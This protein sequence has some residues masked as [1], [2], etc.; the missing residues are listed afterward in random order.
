VGWILP[1]V[2]LPADTGDSTPLQENSK[3]SQE[4]DQ[5]QDGDGPE[6]KQIPFFQH[7]SHELLE[8]NGF[9]QH[10]YQKFHARCLKERKRLGSGQSSEM[11]TLFRF[12][13]HFLRSHFSK[14][15]YNEFK[16]LALEDAQANYRYGLECLFRFFSYGLENKFRPFLC[17]DFQEFTL[18]DFKDGS[19]YGLEKFWAF[20]K[21]RKDKN[22][23]EMQPELKK[24]LEKYRSIQDFR[25]PHPSSV[26]SGKADINSAQDF[27]PLSRGS[28][29]SLKPA[30]SSAWTTATSNSLTNP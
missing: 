16:Q 6:F 24:L 26:A 8:E 4:K 5:S 20:L 1:P 10:K 22:S 30:L 11:N 29:S 3:A 12:W 18:K 13:S 25:K 17:C 2:G 21:Y 7:P 9:I 19:L 28:S 23:V 15:M 14:R 27:P